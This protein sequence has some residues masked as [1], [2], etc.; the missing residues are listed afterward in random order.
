[1]ACTPAILPRCSPNELSWVSCAS[2]ALKCSS[3]I[4]S[5]FCAV[6][7]I[8]TPS[9]LVT[10]S[11]SPACAVLFC[12]KFFMST[13]PVTASPKMGSGAS[14]LWPP[15]SGIPASRQMLRLPSK[16]FW[17]TAAGNTLIRPAQNG[18]CHYRSATHCI[19]I[20]DGVGRSDTPE[21]VRVVYYRH[22]KIR[23]AYHS[24]TVAQVIHCCIVFA[25][26]AHQQIF[27][28][29]KRQLALQYFF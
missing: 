6:D 8:P 13:M 26:I 1:M 20:A 19:H 16:T 4:N 21:I 28:I 7:K 29:R 3:E 27:F 18:N 9:F 2:N 17:A 12:F 10:N 23:C 22:K 5:R 15:A 14:M 25:A 11:R 24:R